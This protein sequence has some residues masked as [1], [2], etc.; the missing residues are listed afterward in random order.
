M[1]SFFSRKGAAGLATLL[2]FCGMMTSSGAATTPL[3]DQPIFAATVPGNLVLDLSVE[4]PTAISVAN[5]GSYS[6]STNYPGYFDPAKCYAYQYN[7]TTPNQSYFQAMAFTSPANTHGC[8]GL[9]WSGNFMNWASMQTIDPFRQVLTGGYRSVDTATQTI[10]EKAWGSNQGSTANFYYRG[11]SQGSPNNLPATLISTLTPMTNWSILNTGIW[12]N[13]NTMLIAQ[14]TGYVASTYQ[15][16]VYDMPTNVNAAAP[17]PGQPYTTA[18]P[19]TPLNVV[20]YRMYIR[21][22]VCDTSVL[23]VAGLESN[24]VKYGSNYKPQGLMQT[25]ANSIRYAAMSYLNS[26]GIYQQGGVLRE[27]MGFIGPTYPTPLSATLTTNT[28]PEWSA[29]DGTMSSNPD[30]TTASSSGVTQSGVMNYVNKFGEYAAAQGN[31]TNT[32]MTYDNVSELYYAAVR[33]YEN[34]GNVTQWDSAPTSTQLDG[35][36][37]V[38]TWTDPILYSCQKNFILGIG[39]D[40]THNDYNVGGSDI[41]GS[42]L[43][44]I[45]RP[46]PTQVAADNFNQATTWTNALEALEGASNFPYGEI[47][48]PTQAN[49]YFIAGLAY[50]THV[51][52]IRSDLTGTQTIST[53]WF[54]VEEYG[55]PENYNQYYLAA[56]YGGFTVP[57]A[58]SLSNTTA[59]PLSEYDTSGNSITMHYG[60]VLPQP[61]NYFLAGNASLMQSGLA[62]AFANISNAVSSYSSAYALS[63]PNITSTGNISYA[64]QYN[65]TNWTDTITAQTFTFDSSG[66]PVTPTTVWVSSSTLQNQLANGGYAS[67]GRLVATWNGSAGVPFEIGNLTSTQQAALVPSSYSSNTTSAQYLKYLRGDQTNEVG[68]TASGSTKSLRARTLLLGDIV[69]ASLAEVTT[70]VQSFSEG[71]NPGYTAFQ[72]QWTTTSPR[73]TMV[74]AAANDGML[75]GFVGSSGLEQFAYVPSATFQGPTGTPQVNGLAALGNPNFAHHYYVDAT[76]IAY[77]IDLNRTGTNAAG[78]G[79][80]NW[81]TLLIG[82][83][84]KGGMSYYA[85]DVT[86]PAGMTSETAVA[87]D[88]EWEFTDSTMGY[89]FG[90]PIV[91]KTAQYGWVVA[92]TSGY[93]SSSSVGYLYLVNPATGALLQK[94]ATPSASSG[95]TQASAYVQ[96]YTDYTADSIYVGDLNGQL[97]RFD[98]TTTSGTYPA[99]TLLATLTDSSGNAQPITTAPLI[100]IHPTTRKRYVMVGTGEFLSASDIT[101]TAQQSFYVIMDGTASSFNTVTTPITRS[102]LTSVTG[103]GLV[104]GITLSA[105][106]KGWYIDLGTDPTSGYAWR[107]DIKPVAYNGTVSFAAFLPSGNACAL[108]GQGEIYS[109]NYATATSILIAQPTGYYAT[110]SAVVNLNYIGLTA[111]GSTSAS[112][113]LIAGLASGAVVKIPQTPPTTSTT[114]LLN[115]RELPTVQ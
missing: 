96:D 67:P 75:H 90:A 99:P 23:G 15:Y 27:P 77:D 36:P 60:N 40:H 61:D 35:F 6:D 86:N 25:Y 46:E 100:E 56:K 88:V 95:L 89:S 103:A 57:S 94:I 29:T 114:R 4:Y 50:G 39:D 49:T 74:Y 16:N 30:S 47:I 108:S 20:T 82:G 112:S 26:Y 38:V 52:D 84:A 106:S 19:N 10:L 17:T 8:G 11:T 7:S 79:T 105:T 2:A 80:P 71:N 65:S 18:V 37:A 13:G 54:D 69:D 42:L 1:N 81:H 101:T 70:P 104:T 59:L 51:L 43:G 12:A 21:V 3:A 83:L 113:E 111:T 93:N 107:V 32:Y 55:Y 31:Y 45:F 109:V 9:Y 73:P 41:A 48:D 53:Y 76:P 63:T 87:A 58:Y 68:S 85:I 24:C 28:R 91:V 72:T 110:S 92:L 33:Y 97:W 115:W 5:I 62:K 102:N 14:G 44:G 22:L 78:T 34:L 98:L 64:S 66:N